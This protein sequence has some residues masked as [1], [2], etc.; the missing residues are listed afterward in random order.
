[1]LEV[2]IVNTED[3]LAQIY[4]LNQINLKQNLSETEKEEEG[5]V[6][7]LYSMDLLKKMH[8]LAP[9]IIAKDQDKVIG[10]ALVT[11]KEASEFHHDLKTMIN[12]LE[13]LQYKN[14]PLFS[15]SFYCMG[16]ICIDKNY[17]GKGVVN[18]LYQHHKKIYQNQFDLLVT[19]ISTNNPR[20]Q[21]AHEKL[22]FKTIHSYH[23]ALDEWNVV[24]WDWQ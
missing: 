19:E 12:S 21:K 13:P 3:E 11:L 9:S 2:A 24:V 18:S 17:R 6:S 5:F 10:Y 15:Y 1:M 16:Q 4:K 23:D 8:Q 14:K 7:W 22:G 20:S